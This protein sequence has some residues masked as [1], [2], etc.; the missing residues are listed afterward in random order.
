MFNYVLINLLSPGLNFGESK[1]KPLVLLSSLPASCEVYYTTLIKGATKLTGD[2]TIGVAF[3]ALSQEL[4]R[5][6]IMRI[7]HSE[8]S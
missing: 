4:Q 5:K 7:S 3:E 1:V 8:K 2:V 6:C